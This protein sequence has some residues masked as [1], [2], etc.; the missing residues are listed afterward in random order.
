MWG[1]HIGMVIV[2]SNMNKMVNLP[3]PPD[4]CTLGSRTASAGSDI[5][6]TSTAC[7]REHRRNRAHC[8]EQEM[9]AAAGFADAFGVRYIRF[10]TATHV[11]SPCP[12][13]GAAAWP[14]DANFTLVLVPLPLASKGCTLMLMSVKLTSFVDMRNQR[15]KVSCRTECTP[16]V[17]SSPTTTGLP[18]AGP[19]LST[20]VCSTCI[21][22]TGAA[23]AI[24]GDDWQFGT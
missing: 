1:T 8:E 3:P 24:G 15:G 17:L 6:S 20:A 18:A 7:A 10:D 2:P 4:T 14:T 5:S 22:A 12:Q 21:A 11:R 13:T 23:A 19:S 16:G 9:P